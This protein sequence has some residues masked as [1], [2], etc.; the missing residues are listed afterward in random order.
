MSLQRCR[1]DITKQNQQQAL[2]ISEHIT[3]TALILGQG[4]M[5][6]PLVLSWLAKS[7]APPLVKVCCVWLPALWEGPILLF[8]FI[9]ALIKSRKSMCWPSG[10]L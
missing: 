9:F 1:L 7:S 5:N 3:T 6:H 10:F 4:N 8:I 2:L